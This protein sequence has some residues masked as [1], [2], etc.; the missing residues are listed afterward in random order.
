MPML[1]RETIARLPKAELHTHLDAALRPETMI[2]LAG[3]GPG[4]HVLDVA[5][6]AGQQSL[7]IARRVGASGKVL[8][9]DIAPEL[10]A[11]AERDASAAGLT[12]VETAEVDGERLDELL[13]DAE[14]SVVPFDA[15]QA[16]IARE[17]HARFGKGSGSKAGLNFGD[18]VTY[19]LAKVTGEP[20]L[21]KGDDF[22]HTD[23]TPAR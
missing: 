23:V 10:L 17:A 3:I 19:A 9:T 11:R 21:F 4:S 7:R 15:A 13:G 14:I 16:R 6:G 1:T 20:L 8:V 5:A 2:E 12:N 18:C 22:A